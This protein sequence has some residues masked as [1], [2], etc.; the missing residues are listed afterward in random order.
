MK[1]IG[2]TE[3]EL[4]F[5]TAER[6]YNQEI[7]LK[8]AIEILKELDINKNSGV[9]YLYNYSKLINGQLFTRTMNISSTIYFLENILKTKGEKILQKALYSLSL[10]IDYY[11]GISGGKVKK[12]KEILNEYVD[13]YGI[14]I[15]DYFGE[16]SAEKVLT[17]GTVRNVKMN[18]YERNAYARKKCIDFHGC[19]CAV[20]DFDF[21]KKYG[22]LG[23]G[24][25]HVHHLIEISKI[26]KEYQIDYK[27]DLIPVCPN[28]HA[29][30]HKKDPA[31]TINELKAIIIK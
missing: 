3:I 30:I 7:T 16:E 12:I 5:E 17:E 23:R 11:E 10:H 14:E 15:D 21:S 20:C 9:D 2:A 27:N 13:K 24:F 28:C 18:V 31:Y 26:K 19:K 6:F 4:L 25:I 1:K 22:E 29:M 8:E